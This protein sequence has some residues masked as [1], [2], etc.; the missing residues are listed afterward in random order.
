MQVVTTSSVET[1]CSLA[2]TG[3]RCVMAHLTRLFKTACVRG[4]EKGRN[5]RVTAWSGALSASFFPSWDAA[6]PVL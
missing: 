3:M 5:A 1:I 6:L 4:K 2:A